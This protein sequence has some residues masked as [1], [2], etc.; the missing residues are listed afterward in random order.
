MKKL[1]ISC[2][3]S[4]VSLSA[5]CQDSSQPAYQPSKM[6]FSEP[7]SHPQAKAPV[8]DS[9]DYN[10]RKLL[11]KSKH[12]KAA[13]HACV[14]TGAGLLTVATLSSIYVSGWGG[15]PFPPEVIPFYVAGFGCVIASIPLFN[16]ST[17][18]FRKANELSA[19]IKLESTRQLKDGATSTINYPSL[20]VRFS[21]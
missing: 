1:T 13:G 11:A 5:V 21:F 9:L 20:S 2:V 4:M 3:L 14:W 16:A 8:I 15:D 10:R 12:F 6:Q 17:K 18:N 19:N 7:A